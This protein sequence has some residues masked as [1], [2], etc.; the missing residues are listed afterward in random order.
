MGG[1]L[2]DGCG[3]SDSYYKLKDVT[4]A[5]CRTC[6][7]EQMFALMQLKM[8]IRVFWIPTVP[9]NTKYAVVCPVCKNGVLV[10]ESQKNEILAGRLQV[11]VTED[12]LIL[13]PRQT[14]EPRRPQPL[15]APAERPRFCFRCGSPLDENGKCPQCDRQAADAEETIRDGQ[16]SKADSAA[17][18]SLLKKDPERSFPVRPQAK[19]CPHCQL[20]YAVDKEICDVCGRTLVIR[21]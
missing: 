6:G 21:E 5:Y 3:A 17:S 8:K 19:I 11:E 18:D 20:L 12:G 2:I 1:M 9:I 15:P 7:R 14:E 16:D 13:H 4:K 10:D